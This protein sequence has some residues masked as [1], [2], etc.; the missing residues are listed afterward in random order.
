MFILNC[1][2][3]AKYFNIFFS[4]QYK[5]IIN[6]SVLPEVNF[7]TEKRFG[8]ITI[9][10]DEIISLIRKIYPGK[11]TG[12]DKISGQMLHLC[13]DHVILPLE[14]IFNNILSSSVYPDMGKIANMTPIFKK[15]DTFNK[16]L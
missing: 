3:N 15:G 6:S 10:N 7:L 4:Q 5:P 16:K 13:D 9:G 12:S 8:H 1:K 2:E 14:L 11:A